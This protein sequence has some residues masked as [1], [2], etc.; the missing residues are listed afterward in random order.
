MLNMQIVQL[1]LM[2]MPAEAVKM[3]TSMQTV[4]MMY[5]YPSEA[6]QLLMLMKIVELLIALEAVQLMTLM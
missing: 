4:Q 6:V 5:K 1:L 2:Q 3:M